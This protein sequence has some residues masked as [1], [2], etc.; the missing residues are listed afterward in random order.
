MY[1]YVEIVIWKC[2]CL[3]IFVDM[4]N[5]NKLSVFIILYIRR[6]ILFKVGLLKGLD[7][8]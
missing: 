8:L 6:K 1:E 7:E 3:I 4:I 2:V 5:Y